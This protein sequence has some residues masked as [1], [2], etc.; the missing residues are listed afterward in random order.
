M[1]I[2]TVVVES[3]L[4]SEYA[5]IMENVG[6]LDRAKTKFMNLMYVY[7]CVRKPGFLLEFTAYKDKLFRCAAWTSATSSQCRQQIAMPFTV[8]E[9]TSVQSQSR[10]CDAA[11]IYLAVTSRFC[12]TAPRH[13][14]TCRTFIYDR[15]LSVLYKV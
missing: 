7:H 10:I 15:L 6:S 14:H 9:C 5:I 1:C 13:S 4:Y 3:L 8:P 2:Y 11:A 12:M